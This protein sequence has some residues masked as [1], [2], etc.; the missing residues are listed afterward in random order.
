M[1]ENETTYESLDSK[2]APEA[3]LQRHKRK[4]SDVVDGHGIKAGGRL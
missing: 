2:I 4:A 1:S 3:L